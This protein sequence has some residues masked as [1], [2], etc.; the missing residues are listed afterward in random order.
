MTRSPEDVRLWLNQ[1]SSKLDNLSPRDVLD[2]H[3]LAQLTDLLDQ[4]ETK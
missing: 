4:M 2:R 3:T 1:K